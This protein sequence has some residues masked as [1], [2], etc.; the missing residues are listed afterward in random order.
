MNN[1][2]LII[3]SLSGGG[4]FS[5]VRT[6]YSAKYLANSQDVALVASDI[7][8]AILVNTNVAA[9]C[10]CTFPS[11]SDIVGYYGDDFKYGLTWEV[12][13]P[14][15]N[16]SDCPTRF[17]IPSDEKV[18]MRSFEEPIVSSNASLF[19]IIN[20]VSSDLSIYTITSKITL[21]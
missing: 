11:Y 1:Q 6:K 5:L 17:V 18:I 15:K 10:V 12:D 3:D 2:P 8:N 4:G 7:D 9:S 20:V 21:T 14:V 19:K 16:A 13:I